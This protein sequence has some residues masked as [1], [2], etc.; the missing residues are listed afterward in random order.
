MAL[1]TLS[2][3]SELTGMERR[4][5]Q[6]RLSGVPP[7]QTVGRVKSFDSA[8]ALAV[9]YGQDGG[10]L[11]PG[12]EKA[13]LDKRRREE[14]EL[15]LATQNGR[16]VAKSDVLR[17]IQD[18]AGIILSVWDVL[19]ARLTPLLTDV[20]DATRVHDILREG[21]DVAQQEIADQLDAIKAGRPR[22]AVLP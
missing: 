19:P 8:K 10:R 20:P 21:V 9:I 11:D 4:T 15:R 22:P 6:R 3:L 16:L 13:L 17:D 1:I 7:V 12:Q 14:V 2:K 18:A 5:L